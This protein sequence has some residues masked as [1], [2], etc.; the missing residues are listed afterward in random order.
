MTSLVSK[1]THVTIRWA[2][3]LIALTVTAASLLQA[4]NVKPAFADTGGY[5]W[6]DA[7]CAWNG[8]PTGPCSSYDWG[9]STCPT[10][11]GYCNANNQINGY[12]L[13]D[14]WGEGFRNCT[15]YAAW[16]LNQAFGIN[17]SNWKNGAD[18]NN[19]ALAAGYS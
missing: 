10:G 17:P 2:A 1:N 5:T 14:K 3:L 19:S 13:Y 6:S 16:K 15:S 9:E 11:D 8:S 4:A 12:Y 18:W 7:P